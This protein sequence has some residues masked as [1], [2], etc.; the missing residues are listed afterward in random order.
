[1]SGVDLRTYIEKVACMSLKEIGV[2]ELH[3]NNLLCVLGPTI[4]YMGDLY[5]HFIKKENLHLDNE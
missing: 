2:F 5:D 3:V 4:I 1:M